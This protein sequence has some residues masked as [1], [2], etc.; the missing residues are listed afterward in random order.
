M[1]K[2]VAITIGDYNGIGIHIL[3]ESWKNN[4]I[5]NFILFSNIDKISKILKNKKIY[6]S[7]NLLKNINNYDS[8]KFNIYSYKAN[9]NEY[10]SYLC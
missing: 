4:E 5:K 1:N 2:I 10:N 9:S 8:K 3:L 6:K 7:V